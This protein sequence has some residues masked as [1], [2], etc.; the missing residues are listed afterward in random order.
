MAVVNTGLPKTDL[1]DLETYKSEL[2]CEYS[3]FLH[4]HPR[5]NKTQE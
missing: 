1:F 2:G 3:A 5:A 4:G